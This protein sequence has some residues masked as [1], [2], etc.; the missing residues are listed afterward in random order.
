MR[1]QVN[2]IL[3]L[4]IFFIG[5]PP[6]FTYGQSINAK[7]NQSLIY[8]LEIVSVKD[9]SLLKTITYKKIF[10]EKTERGKELRNVLLTC[11]DKAYLTAS[12]DSLIS[13][14]L[15][16]KAY[17]T[18]GSQYK[19]AFLKNENVDE[20]VLSEIGF[21]EKLYSN[22]PIYYKSV[23]RIQE[24]LITYY[25]NNG[26]PFASVK[27][28]SIVI[29]GEN[30]SAKL[31]LTKNLQEKIDSVLIKGT[32]KI[33]PV[34]IYNYLGIKPGS[35]YNEGQLK[36]VNTRLAEIPFV[37]SSKPATVIFNNKFNKLILNLDNK[38]ASQFDG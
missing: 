11:F 14:S 7:T 2:W 37:R 36:K 20:G 12:Y 15:T 35:L 30:I 27:L 17:L 8:S 26:Y 28:D 21:R 4:L 22:K 16:L 25:E 1:F 10:A 34:Y 13:D 23:K 5:E 19:W 38:Q 18:F 6:V 9:H 3:S 29:S 31:K 33:A 24:K 32:A